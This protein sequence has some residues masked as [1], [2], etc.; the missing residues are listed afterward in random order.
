MRKLLDDIYEH[1]GV[2]YH[3]R[4]TIGPDCCLQCDIGPRSNCKRMGIS[5]LDCKCL[6]GATRYLKRFNNKG[7]FKMQ[8]SDLRFKCVIPN[9]DGEIKLRAKL[10][11][12]GMGS[13]N[14]LATGN[15]F[16]AFGPSTNSSASPEYFCTWDLPLVSYEQALSLIDSV[17]DPAPKFDIKAFD[18]ILCRSASDGTWRASIFSGIVS[19]GFETVGGSVFSQIMRYENNEKYDRSS[20][21]PANYW[22]CEGRLPIWQTKA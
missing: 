3:G 18:K 16:F 11:T 12:K 19:A 21:A 15:A 14:A 6:V 10:C 13:L 22:T 5:G 1:D 4:D 20:A 7:E 9:K 2:L 8:L 17:E